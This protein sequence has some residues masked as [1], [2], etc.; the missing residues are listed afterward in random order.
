MRS[1]ACSERFAHL[2]LRHAEGLEPE[3]HILEHREPREERE[4]LPGAQREVHVLEHHQ[5]IAVRL[6]E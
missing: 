1:I 2:G 6:A 3:L 4:A 5:L